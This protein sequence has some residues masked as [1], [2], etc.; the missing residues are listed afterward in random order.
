MTP[1]A[2]QRPEILKSIKKRV[3]ANHI[4]VAGIDYGAWAQ[5]V[6]DV[7]PNCS[8]VTCGHSKAA[9]GNFWRNSRRA[10]RSLLRNSLCGPMYHAFASSRGMSR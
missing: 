6:D 3:L 9:W 10:T 2:K 4:N 7:P 1:N 8:I 5:H